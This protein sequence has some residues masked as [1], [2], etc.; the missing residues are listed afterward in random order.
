MRFG[1][2]V[3]QNGVRFRLWA[4]KCNE[5]ALKIEG[6]PER[7]PMHALANGWHEL[8]VPSR[9]PG[10]LYQF[11]LP[12]GRLIPDP[13]SRFQPHD[14]HGPS[15]VIDPSAYRWTDA[16][17]RGRPWEEC[18]LYELHVGAFTGE[19]TFR[20]VGRRLRD[21]KDLGITA[22]ELMPV[23]DFPGERNWGYDGVLLFAPDSSYGRPEDLKA[24]VDAAHALDIVVLLDVVYN[25][26]G[27]DGN[28]LPAYAPIFSDRH[29]TPWGAAINY[30]A[31]GSDVVREF[32]TANAIYWIRE[33]NFDGLRL[34]AVHAILDDSSPHLLEQIAM[35]VRAA[36]PDRH[37]HL[38]LEN[39]ENHASRLRRVGGRPAEFTAQWNDDAHHVLHTAATGESAGYYGEYLGDTE[40]L[41]RALAEGFAFQGQMMTYRGRP[42]GEASRGLPPTA[43][44]A[45]IQNHD[46][47]GN[48][49]FGDRITAFAAP[50]AVRAIAAIYLLAPQIPMLFMGEEWAAAQPFPFFCD[51]GAELADAVRKGRREEFDKFPEF[52]NPDNLAKVPDPTVPETFLSAKLRWED[53]ARPP[54]A[55][56]YD[57]YRRVLAVRHKDVIP[58][59][60][61]IGG[62]AGRYQVL[63]DLAV[64]VRW[65]MGD[66]SELMLVANLKETAQPP[67]RLP[68]GRL[69]WLEG[70]ADDGA[71]GP[72]TVVWMLADEPGSRDDDAR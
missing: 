60:A 19:G 62:H 63:G 11:V 12:D 64:M 51:F 61:G 2:E 57:W 1:A 48:R 59:L 18:V 39:E 23:A 26:L 8:M 10:T 28:H 52:Q 33:Y 9:G 45:F 13:A 14:V 24:L 58:R 32:V 44:V 3:S 37:V 50:E 72:W 25:H 36:A 49:A 7:M 5:L 42:R 22:I 67:V 30:D 68:A 56:W 4:P 34:D 53:R 15:E 35:Q 6:V 65:C 29:H 46:Q 41:G 38:V 20:A 31:D 66:A 55:E 70:A 27:P 71:L 43:F 47:V 40:L 69:L 16:E 17:W 21:L 54:H